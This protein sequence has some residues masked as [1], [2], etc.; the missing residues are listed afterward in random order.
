MSKHLR[1]GVIVNE[2]K[3]LAGSGLEELRA[4]LADAGQADPPWYQV[5]KSK[6]APKKI[7]KLV[8]DEGVDRLLVWG[9]DGTVR[10]A[11]DTLLRKGYDH[12]ALAMLPAGTGNLLAKNLDIPIDLRG[13]V[14]VALHGVAER[15]DAGVVNDDQHFLVMAGTGF[16][17]L[18][19]KDAED[20]GAKDRFGRLGYIWAGVHNRN[21]SPARAE[22][23]IDG[24]PWF[25]GDASCVIAG[26]V[27]TLLGGI[28]AFP[29]ASPTDGRLDVGVIEARR[30][31]DWA[32][33]FGSV[34][35]RRAAAS[36]FASVTRA[37]KIRIDLDRTL[38]WQVDGGDRDRADH[39][40][41]RCLPHAVSIYRPRRPV[42]EDP[43]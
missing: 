29:D 5:A 7:V 1:I 21:I 28:P 23:T 19:I 41:I 4:A 38:P 14:D 20:S 43:S 13:A 22:V 30:P 25:T 2:G 39:F 32:R 33:L 3:Q 17:A 10:R 18:M 11:A 42:Q 16:D 8:E 34:L 9:G 26:N 24:E 31:S 36:P 40:E 35:T 6:Q 37:K 27:G 15:I 12:V